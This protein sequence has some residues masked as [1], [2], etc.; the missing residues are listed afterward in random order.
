MVI[1]GTCRCQGHGEGM[2]LTAAETAA[3]HGA[4]YPEILQR[5]YPAI[6]LRPA[7]P[8]AAAQRPDAPPPQP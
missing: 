1:P 6:T 8:A 4:R 5:F 3:A 2:D 7:A